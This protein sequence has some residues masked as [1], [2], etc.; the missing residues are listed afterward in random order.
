MPNEYERGYINLYIER[1]TQA[2]EGADLDF[3]VGKS[4]SEI[5]RDSH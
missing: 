5:K 4:G 2:H 1:V 3:L